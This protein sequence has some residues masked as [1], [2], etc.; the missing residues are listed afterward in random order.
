MESSSI[1]SCVLSLSMMEEDEHNS[2]QFSSIPKLHS[3]V[4]TTTSVHDLLECP[5][6]TNS[7]YPPIH[8][9]S[10]L[11]HFAYRVWFGSL[12]DSVCLCSLGT[13][14]LSFHLV[15]MLFACGHILFV[16]SL[17]RGFFFF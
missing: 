12:D 6:C 10:Y 9:V 8:Q 15:F 14:F 4:P 5:V 17:K 11:I 2:H 3:N 1:D 7:M 16:L 13:L